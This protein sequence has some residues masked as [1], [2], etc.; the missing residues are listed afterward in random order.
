VAAWYAHR[1]SQRR[2][3]YTYGE[4]M[5]VAL[6]YAGIEKEGWMKLWLR[7]GRSGNRWSMVYQG[8]GGGY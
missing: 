7:I 3:S 2:P 4:S 6:E 8:A 5:A 1:R